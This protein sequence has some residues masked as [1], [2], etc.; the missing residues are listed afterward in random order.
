MPLKKKVGLILVSPL[1]VAALLG[2]LFYF[3][4]QQTAY[5]SPLYGAEPD[6]TPRTQ[7]LKDMKEWAAQKAEE[8]ARMAELLRSLDTEKMVQLG[9]EIVNG[10]GLCFNCH[11]IGNIG[12]GTQGPNL[13]GVGARAGRRVQGLSDVEYL[14]Q[15]LYD[16]DAFVVP[17]FSPAMTPANKPPIGLSD[18]E[19]MMVIAYLQSLGGTATITPDTTLPYPAGKPTPVQ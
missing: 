3:L 15:S 12:G 1:V 6:R 8:E 2:A 14:T 4:D 11:S 19:I 13:E 7:A 9:K 10:K 16:P 18:L 5:H 17:D